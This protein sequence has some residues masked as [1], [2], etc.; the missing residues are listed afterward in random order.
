M[1]YS[2]QKYYT[3]QPVKVS[4]N[5][6]LGTSTASGANTL[7]VTEGDIFDPF[8]KTRILS[9]KAYV[10]TAA[11]TGSTD[12]QLEVLNG[13]DTAAV[14]V[15]TTQTA[16][17]WVDGTVTAANALFGTD[18]AFTLQVTG[19]ATA[20]GDSAADVDLWFEVRE[21]FA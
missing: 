17:S 10:V 18:T 12:W 8:R 20:S 11:D 21:N 6:D 9:V 15:L 1:A 16:G 4:D 13:T 19:T 5:L 3:R 7:A 2:D 14:I